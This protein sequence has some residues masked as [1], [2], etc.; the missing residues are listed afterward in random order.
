MQ[1]ALL[2]RTAF[3]PRV[4]AQRTPCQRGSSMVV[5]AA[6]A[7][8]EVTGL[9]TMRKGVKEV[10]SLQ[11][12]CSWQLQARGLPQQHGTYA[13]GVMAA[14]EF[15]CAVPCDGFQNCA[16]ALYGHVAG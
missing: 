13:A 2:G 8:D 9:K 16:D 4:V 3:C 11:Q 5:R 10:G 7:V 1:S 14:L 15:A 6:A 12:D